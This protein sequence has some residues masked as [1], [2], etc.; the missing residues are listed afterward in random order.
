MRYGVPQ[1]AAPQLRPTY[2]PPSSQVPTPR[3]ELSHYYSQIYQGSAGWNRNQQMQSTA[4][5]QNQ[6]APQFQN[7]D[8]LKSFT[9]AVD[10]NKDGM[11]STTERAAMQKAIDDRFGN[12]NGQFRMDDFSQFQWELASN[13]PKWVLNTLASDVKANVNKAGTWYNGSNYAKDAEAAFKTLSQKEQAGFGRSN[14]TFAND[15]AK[16]TFGS[17]NAANR[18]VG[19]QI[20]G[21]IDINNDGMV[22]MTEQAAL[23]QYIDGKYGN[24]DGNV[25]SA[26][27]EKY[28]VQLNASQRSNTFDAFLR[29]VHNYVERR[30]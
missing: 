1:Q 6:F 18:N 23:H 27:L 21:A 12:G 19:T 22:S 28:G 7:Q 15:F 24:K 8:W 13:D 10:A 17:I 2:N 14:Y 30:V 16:A 9:Q 25:S 11:I 20:A 29:D 4:S 3:P 26:E 5:F